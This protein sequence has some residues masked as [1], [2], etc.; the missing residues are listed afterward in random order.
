MNL[1]YAAL[2]RGAGAEGECEGDMRV[3]ATDYT[4]SLSAFIFFLTLTNQNM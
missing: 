3:A 4:T 1:S 2:T